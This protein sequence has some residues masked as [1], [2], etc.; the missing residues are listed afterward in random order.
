MSLPMALN[1]QVAGFIERQQRG[2]LCQVHLMAACTCQRGIGS[3]VDHITSHRMRY[4]VFVAVACAAQ[5]L[6]ILIQIA[7]IVRA[8]RSM[9]G[10]AFQAPVTP[11]SGILGEFVVLGMAA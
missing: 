9:A 10:G 5:F 2:V 8:V 3:G 1:A 6:W 7:R 11:D 4:S